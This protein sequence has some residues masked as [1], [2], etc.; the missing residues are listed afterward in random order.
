MSNDVFS[1]EQILGP[2][3][4]IARRL[5]A[6]ETRPEQ[7]A[8]AVAVEQAMQSGHHLVAEAGTGVGKSFAYLIPAILS[9]AEKKEGRQVQ[10]HHCFNAYD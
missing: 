2:D 8:L 5:D 9:K 7:M 3:G 1:T 6:Y 10:T 4:S